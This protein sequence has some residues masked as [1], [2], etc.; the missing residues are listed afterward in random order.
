M[1][2]HNKKLNSQLNKEKSK[3]HVVNKDMTKTAPT[4]PQREPTLKGMKLMNK[5]KP[6][7]LNPKNSSLN[8]DSEMAKELAPQ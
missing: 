8:T 4:F 7:N 6:T 2:L 1:V 5:I 3:N